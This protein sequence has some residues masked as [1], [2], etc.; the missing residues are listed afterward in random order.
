MDQ[1]TLAYVPYGKIVATGVSAE[2]YMSRY[3]ADHYEWVR[4]YVIQMSPSS[5][6]HQRRLQYLEDV[7]KAYFALNP[8]GQV[9]TETFVMRL[10]STQSR[11]EPDLMVVLNDNSGEL[12]DTAMIGPADICIEVVSPESAT[13]DYGEK[14]TE[15]EAGGVAE[16]WIIDPQREQCRFHRL[17]EDGFYKQIDLDN[18]HY[19]TPL[20]PKLVVDV[21]TLWQDPLPNYFQIG[22]A[23]KKMFKGSST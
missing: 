20:L 22:E 15:Y 7:L 9:I 1:P 19:T 21:P 23:V 5:L 4:G 8:I 18:E 11:R 16:Y 2:E 17:G 12:T 13:R 3:A 6:R 10:D 14:Y